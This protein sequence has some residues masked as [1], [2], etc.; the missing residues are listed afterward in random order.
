MEQ[1]TGIP[2]ADFVYDPATQP[3]LRGPTGEVRNRAGVDAVVRRDEHAGCFRASQW[4]KSYR[5]QLR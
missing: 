4:W 2:I 1:R 5:E 3:L